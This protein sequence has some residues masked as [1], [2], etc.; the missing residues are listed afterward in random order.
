MLCK[1]YTFKKIEE[2]SEDQ[3]YRII[4]EYPIIGKAYDIVQSFKEILFAKKTEDLDNWIN[5]AALLEID[6]IN[7]F[8]GGIF[9]D[10]GAVKNAIKYEYSNGLA[11]GS[12]NKL[13]LIKRIMYGRNSYKLLKSK[14]LRLE[15]KRKIN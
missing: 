1:G 5:E 11:E 10:I 7:S 14:L 9:R 12:V 15:L 6:E 3:L 13:K 8:I 2:L 4:I